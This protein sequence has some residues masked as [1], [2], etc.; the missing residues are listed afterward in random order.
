MT[1]YYTPKERQLATMPE[2]QNHQ[3]YKFNF[4]FTVS[5]QKRGYVVAAKMNLSRTHTT[6]FSTVQ[7]M[8]RPDE[9]WKP[10]Y[11]NWA[12]IRSRTRTY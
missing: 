5:G 12:T 9:T 10:L 1:S 11:T 2:L 4:S 6:F 7:G 8:L 3:P